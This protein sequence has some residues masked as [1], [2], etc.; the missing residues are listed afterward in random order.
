[1]AGFSE[2]KAPLN[3]ESN[4]YPT[5]MTSDNL[6]PMTQMVNGGSTTSALPNPVAGSSFAPTQMVNGGSTTF[7]LPELQAVA[8][9]QRVNGGG[10]ASGTFPM[11][12]GPIDLRALD[13]QPIYSNSLVDD[14]YASML[15]EVT[16]S[17]SFFHRTIHAHLTLPTPMVYL[18]QASFL[19]A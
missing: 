15:K 6:S 18:S 11:Q 2:Q 19:A 3:M 12:E 7:A 5:K 13:D 1:V 9:T 10:N 4:T 14:V 17:S 16:T 8:P